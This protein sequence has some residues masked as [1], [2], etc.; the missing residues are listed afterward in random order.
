M[1]VGLS[2]LALKEPIE[3]EEP[4][5]ITR[6]HITAQKRDIC[7]ISSSGLREAE[8]ESS[9]RCRAAR[10]LIRFLGLQETTQN[11]S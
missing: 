6:L 2:L 1:G 9:I 8:A 3:G 11:I 10:F 5:K 7:T 4:L